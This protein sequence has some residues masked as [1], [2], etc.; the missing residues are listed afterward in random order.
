MQSY[1]TQLLGNVVVVEY[2]GEG[3][4]RYSTQRVDVFHRSRH[5]EGRNKESKHN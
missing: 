3:L 1:W 5:T 2:S 4:R